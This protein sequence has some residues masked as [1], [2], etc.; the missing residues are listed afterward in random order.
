MKKNIEG[1]LLILKTMN[2]KPNFSDLART[3]GMDRHTISKLWKEGGKKKVEKRNRHSCLDKYLDEINELMQKPGVNRKAVY[4]YLLD[5]Y[6][7]D[8]IKS[9]ANFKYY[10]WLRD[11][12][13]KKRAQAH[14]RYETSPGQQL[15]VDWKENVTLHTKKGDEITFN[16]MSS[17]LGYSRMHVFIYTKGKTTEDFLRCIIDTLRKL[18]GVPK[19][20]LTDNMTAV[21]SITNG[22]RKK[23][24]KIISFEN[25]CGVKIKLCK[26]RTPETKG[27]DESANRF[28]SWI[29]PYD[30]EFEDENE[31]IKI[32][33][34]INEKVNREINQTT[35]IPPITLF[36]KEKEYLTQLPNNVLLD[37]YI[38][39]S[40]TQTVPQTLLVRY[41]G[42]EYSVPAKYIGKRVKVYPIDTKLYI[43]FNTEL[44]RVHEIGEKKFN[45]DISDYKE[46]LAQAIGNSNVDIDKLA[47]E[48]LKMYDKM[49]NGD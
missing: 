36:E 12:N 41:K 40:F 43:Y 20:I 29:M 1:E 27:K 22:T 6:G 45:Y 26:V 30:R 37:S 10:C 8:K 42:K 38:E 39:T 47:S 4:E 46:G 18:G 11:I 33:E 3:Y 5:K 31:L 17:T 9:Y 24:N 7:E 15:Q 2:I 14:V 19:E 32:L 35:N 48:D 21:V 16:V 34:R 49:M 13:V 44:I 23:H 28:L 25:D